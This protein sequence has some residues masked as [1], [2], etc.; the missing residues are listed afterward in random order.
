MNKYRNKK[1]EVDG[2]VFDSRKEAGRYLELK[3]LQDANKISGLTLQPRFVLQDGFV[4]PV[5]GN[6]RPIVYIA[7]FQYYDGERVVVEDVKGIKTDVYKIKK[8]MFL[9]A[10][11]LVDFREV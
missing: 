3:Q 1:S 9:K 4:H 7:D 2:Y 8:K 6:Q 11:P 5:W 10:Y